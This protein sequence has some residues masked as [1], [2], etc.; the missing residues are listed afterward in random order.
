MRFFMK[1]REVCCQSVTLPPCLLANGNI[2]AHLATTPSDG[3]GK[4]FFGLLVAKVCDE[5]RDDSVR[6]VACLQI[7]SGRSLLQHDEDAKGKVSTQCSQ[8]T[9]KS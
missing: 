5:T 7:P 6:L 4:I 2:G 9:F 8:D 1:T 3:G